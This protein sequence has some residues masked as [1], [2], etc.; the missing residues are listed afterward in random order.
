MT[1]PNAVQPVLASEPE[2]RPV[3]SEVVAVLG[4]HR[5]GTSLI[6]R[7]LNLIGVDLGPEDQL[8]AAHRDDN[9]KG[10]WENTRIVELNDRILEAVGGT[11]DRP[12]LLADGWERSDR[13]DT[14]RDEAREIVSEALTGGDVTGW[15]DPRT[16][17]LLPFWE[18]VVPVSASI[19][20]I[21]HPFQVVS[22]LAKRDHM[23]PE[24]AARLW[25]RHVVAA[26]RAHENRVVINYDLALVDPAL[27]AIQLA[28]S[29][30]LA[31]P[32]RNVL[33][34]IASFVDRSL[35]RNVDDM[36]DAR[37]EMAL[38]LAIYAIVES[39]PFSMVGAV[40][41]AIHDDWLEARAG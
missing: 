14:F 40:L 6:A 33:V 8:M 1:P 36:F 19:I 7:I 29:L 13:L 3:P 23:R 34:E 18:T 21:R 28:D 2:P 10:Y 15:K 24:E 25:S 35:N 12:P 39:Q 30:G 11:W 37:P 16:S 41:D 27:C 32:D 22:S 31:Q 4:M 9:P 5:S 38:A 17:L 26:W 20:V